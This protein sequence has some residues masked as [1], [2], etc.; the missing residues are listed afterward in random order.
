MI[1]DEI[2]GLETRIANLE[3]DLKM[4]HKE[5]YSHHRRLVVLAA[6]VWE[7]QGQAAA[8]L[9]EEVADAAVAFEAGRELGQGDQRDA[10]GDRT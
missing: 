9:V 5:L 8:S 10:P 3:A 4:V 7:P 1:S 2:Q 6:A